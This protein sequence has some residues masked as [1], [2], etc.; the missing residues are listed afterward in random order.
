MTKPRTNG[1]LPKTWIKRLPKQ[2]QPA[3]Q[4]ALSRAE[5]VLAQARKSAPKTDAKK[6][7]GKASA[8]ATRTSQGI[9]H[10]AGLATKAEVDALNKKLGALNKKVTQQTAAPQQES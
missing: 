10:A 3:A 4:E 7:L 5:A 1:A 8:W 9:Y 2:A 6:L